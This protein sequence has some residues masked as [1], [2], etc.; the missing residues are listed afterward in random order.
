MDKRIISRKERE[1]VEL[2][3][4]P[5][6]LRHKKKNRKIIRQILKN[7]KATSFPSGENPDQDDG[8]DCTE[9]GIRQ[10]EARLNQQLQQGHRP[11]VPLKL[12]TYIL[13]EKSFI[14]DTTDED[15]NCIHDGWN[16]DDAPG[17]LYIEKISRQGDDVEVKANL[18]FKLG[19]K[20]CLKEQVKFS[21]SWPDLE[22]PALEEISVKFC[23]ESQ[24]RYR[25]ASQKQKEANQESMRITLLF[26]CDGYLSMR[27]Q[28]VPFYTIR[29]DIEFYGIKTSKITG[30][31]SGLIE[32]LEDSDPETTEPSDEDTTD[33]DSDLD[34]DLL[35]SDYNKARAK[36]AKHEVR[37][38]AIEAWLEER[39][40]SGE[41]E[42]VES[43]EARRTNLED[44]VDVLN[45]SLYSTSY[46][47]MLVAR[48]MRTDN[49][50]FHGAGCGNFTAYGRRDDGSSGG[51]LHLSALEDDWEGDFAWKLKKG[52]VNSNQRNAIISN[53]TLMRELK[54]RI[55][56]VENGHMKIRI[57]AHK[58][59][60]SREDGFIDFYAIADHPLRFDPHRRHGPVRRKWWEKTPH[61]LVYNPPTGAVEDSRSECS[62]RP[63]HCTHFDSLNPEF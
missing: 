35:Y 41:E 1:Q 61:G 36:H 8:D 18:W 31:D 2:R 47:D 10:I 38:K 55:C 5:E 40:A 15:G 32:R 4:L 59:G 39:I 19:P 52:V 46:L 6:H 3:K 34:D 14:R 53:E 24:V 43:M 49:K 11:L 63:D 16:H 28:A 44:Y 50:C 33:S 48:G 25:G 12:G 27:A 21:G 13:T 56:F 29:E 30:R 20:T 9:R 37:G 7:R 23:D 57:Q 51:S 45:W 60:G 26:L 54:F 62:D 17:R 58:I 22:I 42:T